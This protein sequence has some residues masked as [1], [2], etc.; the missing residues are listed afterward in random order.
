MPGCS[1]LSLEVAYVGCFEILDMF[2][3]IR[4]GGKQSHDDHIFTNKPLCTLI[5]LELFM[6]GKREMLLNSAGT[7][8]GMF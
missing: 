3:N 8:W 1:G 7:E 5:A 2:F 6:D 4:S